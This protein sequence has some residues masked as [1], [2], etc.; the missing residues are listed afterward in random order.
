MTK[1]GEITGVNFGGDLVTFGSGSTESKYPKTVLKR[2]NYLISDMK[3][4][5][6]Y[7]VYSTET[8]ILYFDVASPDD[9]KA[10]SGLPNKQNVLELFQNNHSLYATS[11]DK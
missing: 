1:E 11:L 7:V 5:D 2:H 6:K 4:F 3:S 8:R 10:I 9:V